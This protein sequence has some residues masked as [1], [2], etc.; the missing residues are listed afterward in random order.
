MDC[1]WEFAGQGE[2]PVLRRPQ[3]AAPRAQGGG[4]CFHYGRLLWQEV[5]L[6][7]GWSLA[8]L[9]RP[10]CVSLERGGW[11]FLRDD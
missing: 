9:S 1:S 8:Q 11:G 4:N 5:H 10:A 6:R 3:A 2:Q 7:K